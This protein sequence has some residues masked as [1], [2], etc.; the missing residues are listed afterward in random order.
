[1]RGHT[2]FLVIFHFIYF[3]SFFPILWPYLFLFSRDKKECFQLNNIFIMCIAKGKIQVKHSVHVV[4]TL[5]ASGMS[6][7]WKSVLCLS[8]MLANDIKRNVILTQMEYCSRG[9]PTYTE[10]MI[11]KEVNIDNHK[12]ALLLLFIPWKIRNVIFPHCSE[13][14]N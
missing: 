12:S 2:S 10:S 8:N 6:L 13:L 4:S 5:C 11:S 1:M 14:K 7:P 9:N 3:V